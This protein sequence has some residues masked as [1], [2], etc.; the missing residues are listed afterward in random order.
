MATEWKAEI[1]K[2][3]KEELKDYS[4][5]VFTDYRG[6][7][8]EQITALRSNL[9]EK[10][11]EF[12]VVKNRFAKRAFS[13]MGYSDTERFFI[14]PTAIAYCNTD[15]SDVC[16]ILINTVKETTLK[17]KGGLVDGVI[18]SGEDVESIAKLPSRQ[19][20]IGRTLMLLNSPLS[21]LVFILGGLLTQFLLTLKAIERSKN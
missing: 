21:G 9:R 3:M 19:A 14:D 11:V 17:M 18:I 2:K 1:L 20:L 5:F 10:Q 13:E 7:N 4:N 12:H 15:I 6:L 16:K 8:V